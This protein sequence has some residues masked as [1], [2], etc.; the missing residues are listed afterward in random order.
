LFILL[1]SGVLFDFLVHSVVLE[2]VENA[3]FFNVRGSDYSIN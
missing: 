3:L 2:Q 1:C